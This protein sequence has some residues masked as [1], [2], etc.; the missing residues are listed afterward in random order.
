MAKETHSIVA[1]GFLSIADGKITEYSKKGEFLGE[2]DV[3]EAL[4]KFDG[5]EVA[6]SIKF[7]KDLNVPSEDEE[8][9]Y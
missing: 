1:K 2:L 7:D 8:A 4:S 3:Q 9:E 5:K 6:F